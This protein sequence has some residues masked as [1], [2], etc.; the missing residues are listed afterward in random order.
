MKKETLQRGTF[1]KIEN[2]E[3]EAKNQS[4]RKTQQKVMLY[5]DRAHFIAM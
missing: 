2:N 5:Q 4:S 3:D 1:Q